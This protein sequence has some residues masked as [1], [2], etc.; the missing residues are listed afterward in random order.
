M[1]LVARYIQLWSFGQ[2]KALNEESEKLLDLN[3]D[4][5]YLF[6]LLMKLEWN[7]ES[8]PRQKF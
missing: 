8:L 7:L 3:Y 4:S 2:E 1:L 6:I 5:Q